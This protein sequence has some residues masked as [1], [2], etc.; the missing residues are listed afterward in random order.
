MFDWQTPVMVISIIAA[1][2]FIGARAWHHIRSLSLRSNSAKCVSGC[3][4]CNIS[5]N[6]R[7]TRCGPDVLLKRD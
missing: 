2:G 4:A 7:H 3:H 5:M 6:N 1:S